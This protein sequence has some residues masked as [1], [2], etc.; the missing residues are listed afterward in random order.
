M[1]R[2]TAISL[3]HLIHYAIPDLIRGKLGAMPA[4][5]RQNTGVGDLEWGG[6]RGGG[7]SN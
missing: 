4:K 1:V 5:R 6:M 2:E 7:D 3:I